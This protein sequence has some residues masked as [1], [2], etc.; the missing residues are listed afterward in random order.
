MRKRFQQKPKKREIATTTTVTE[1]ARIIS[2]VVE[3]NE[4]SASLHIIP[5]T[6]LRPNVPSLF[7]INLSIF[8]AKKEDINDSGS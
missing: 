7:R 6:Y 8:K 4:L 2:I 5:E 1:T 3:T